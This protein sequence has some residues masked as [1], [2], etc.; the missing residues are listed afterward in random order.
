MS[1]N[2]EGTIANVREK[3]EK[4][5]RF[6]NSANA[7]RN[8]TS[9]AD[10]LSRLN[11]Q[12]RDTRRNIDYFE[13]TLQ[14]LEMKKMGSGMDNMSLHPGESASRKAGNPLTPPPKDGWNGYMGQ[15]QGD[16]GDAQGGYSQLSGGSVP[17]PQSG[18]FPPPAPSAQVKRPNYSKLGM[19]SH[20][21]APWRLTNV[22]GQICSKTTPR[23]S[24]PA[25]S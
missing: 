1:S 22:V 2:I 6:L 15:D 14:D 24:D 25:S 21:P 17:M 11:A 16:Y 23:I 7:M 4:E 18:P 9:N 12:L 8:S 3:L 19:S 5:R 20:S 10:V 13:N